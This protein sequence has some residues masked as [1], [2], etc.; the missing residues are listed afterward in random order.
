MQKSQHIKLCAHDFFISL[1]F[2]NKS[3]SECDYL[4]DN[5]KLLFLSFAATNTIWV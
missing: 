4:A 1:L 2:H 3:F 5:F